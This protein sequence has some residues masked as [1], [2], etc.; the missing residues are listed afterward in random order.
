MRITGNMINYYFVCQRKLWLFTHQ[1]D[2]EDTSEAVRI[3]KIIDESTYSR[4][5]KQYQIDG[6]INVD[7][8]KNWSTIHEV[9]KAKSIEDA[10][11]WQ[12]KYY[13]YYL[14]QRGVPIT[15]GILDYP[16][17][18]QRQ[19]YQLTATDRKRIRSILNSIQE[20]VNQPN[21]PPVHRLPYCK[22]CAYYEYC[23][24]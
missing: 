13:M 23:F 16:K 17:L 20:V 9:K 19:E 12:L 1:L 2:F 14:E 15:K 8:I 11:V 3:G 22:S 21:V 4:E 10:A 5:H 7:M 18:F 6:I 24:S